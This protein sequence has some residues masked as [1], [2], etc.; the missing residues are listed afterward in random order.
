VSRGMGRWQRAIVERAK[1]GPFALVTLLSLPHSKA[2]F[3][4]L[5]RAAGQLEG[6]GVIQLCRYEFFTDEGKVWATLPGQ[7]WPDRNG[8]KDDELRRYGEWYRETRSA[9]G[10]AKY[11]T[12]NV[13]SYE[14]RRARERVEQR[15]RLSVDGCS[16]VSMGKQ[17]ESDVM[18]NVT[19]GEE[20][21]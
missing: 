8:K 21:G 12:R 18:R 3:N 16:G 1:R 4:A 6:R 2:Q 5:Y 19:P 14:E 7:S 10:R 20:T 11:G 13:E 9:G 17:I 15:V